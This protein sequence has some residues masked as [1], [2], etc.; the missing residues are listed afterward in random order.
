MV[1][2]TD[3]DL[4]ARARSGDREAFG[5]LIER[6][7][8]LV[9]SVALRMV[10]Q[11]EQAGELA[12]E[13]ILQAFLSLDRLREPERF[14]S[15]LYGIVVNVCRGYLREMKAGPLS[16]EQLSEGEPFYGLHPVDASA[17][18]QQVVEKMELRRQLFSAIGDLSANQRETVELFYFRH[19]SLQEIAAMLGLSI[20][21]VKVRLHR[22]RQQLRGQ[23]VHL[24]PEIDFRVS[25]EQRRQTMIRVKVQDII[26]QEDR[27][28]LVLLDE[29]GQ[30]YLPIWIGP[31]EA[32]SI[33]MG[34]RGLQT[35]RP[36]TYNFIATMIAALDIA[37]EEVRVEALKEETFYGVARLR[38]G[39]TT[40]EIDA[41]PSDVLAVA[42][43]TSSPIFVG[44]EVMEK[45]GHAV[46]GALNPA[47]L[48]GEGI[49]ALVEEF[50]Q[51][52][53]G[54]RV[55]A[56]QASGAQA[57]PVSEEERERCIRELVAYVERG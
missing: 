30:R 42:V 49:G 43:H 57:N 40:R 5:Q 28:I 34:L 7:Q 11:E 10:W 47:F 55:S 1:E 44:E 17:D 19:L 20:E 38:Q 8:A 33:A 6:Y 23:L 56:A 35:P 22:A 41:R 15:W 26:Q 24:Y 4:V 50:N 51:Q 46:K 9:K 12:Q 36:M 39:Q 27:H 52:I 14:R 48:A 2:R 53:R 25:I 32:R 54:A 18:P 16:L 37:L 29:S 21:A 3:S 45:A 31:Y 13:A